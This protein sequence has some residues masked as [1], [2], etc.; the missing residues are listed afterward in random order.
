MAKKSKKR[1][2]AKNRLENVI[3]ATAIINLL[4]QIVELIRQLF[5]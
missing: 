5:D 1:A 4:V 2:A 3:F